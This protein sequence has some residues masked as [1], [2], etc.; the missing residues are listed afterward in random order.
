MVEKGL[1]AK[2][3]VRHASQGAA[4]RGHADVAMR[5]RGARGDKDENEAEDEDEGGAR[6]SKLT[7]APVLP[8]LPC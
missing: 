8:A 2:K 6:G 1:H 5:G 4:G 3:R 7:P